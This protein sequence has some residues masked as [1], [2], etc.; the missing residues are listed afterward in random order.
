MIIVN[1]VTTFFLEE[2][3]MTMKTTR[4]MMRLLWGAIR[5]LSPSVSSEKSR[6]TTQAVQAQ[7]SLL[8]SHVRLL[9]TQ[10]EQTNSIL[11]SVFSK[12]DS[13]LCE[14]KPN[15]NWPNFLRGVLITLT[16]SNNINITNNGK[17][18]QT[19]LILRMPLLQ[20]PI[21]AN[22]TS[23]KIFTMPWKLQKGRRVVQ[24]CLRSQIMRHEGSK[25]RKRSAEQSK[26]A[27]ST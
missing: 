22:T 24:F 9:A 25:W 23:P 27:H 7:F 13:I 21:L 12:Q 16:E 19:S 5:W 8:F 15:T 14:K 10:C 4:A 3:V 6:F 20:R 26:T 2:M 17:D 18:H 1:S 11:I